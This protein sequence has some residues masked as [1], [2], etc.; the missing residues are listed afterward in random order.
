M[1]G[2][3]LSVPDPVLAGPGQKQSFTLEE[4]GYP[5]MQARGTR[6]QNIT[7]ILPLEKTWQNESEV[8]LDLHFGHSNVLNSRRSSVTVEVNGTAAGSITLNQENATNAHTTFHLPARLFNVGTNT[9]TIAANLRL[10]DDVEN[11][12]DCMTNHSLESW[13]VI[14]ADSLITL[15]GETSGVFITLADYPSAYTGN[16]S[17]SDVAFVVPDQISSAISSAIL[18]LSEGL[19][20]TAPGDNFYPHVISHSGFDPA[21]SPYR[22]HYL[23]GRPSQNSAFEKVGGSLPLPYQSGTDTPQDVEGVA[24]IVSSSASAGYIQAFLGSQGVPNIAVAGSTDEGVLWAADVLQN[25]SS[26]SKLSGDLAILDGPGSLVSAEIRY[27]AANRFATNAE[28]EVVAPAL[29]IAGKAV[30][31]VQWIVYAAAAVFSLTILI[32]IIFI[33]VELQHRKKAR[34]HHGSYSA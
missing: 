13:L 7:Y 10:A 14:Y 26:S 8:L 19:G 9:I 18:R 21:N 34:A 1:M 5:D 11:D 28:T 2:M 12:W 17:L 23:V 31:P 6:E 25:P 4:L 30:Q 33:V 27:K 29:S 22:Y 15:P 20:D 32:L 3:V 16:A 24:R